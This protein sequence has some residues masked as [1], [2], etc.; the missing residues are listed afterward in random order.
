MDHVRREFIQDF[1]NGLPDPEW[2]TNSEISIQQGWIRLN[3]E[4]A[5]T[6]VRIFM[7]HSRTGWADDQHVMAH[8]RQ[9][10]R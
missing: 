1:F 4:Q 8:F 10:F 2:Q 9:L 3:P 7:R 6:L 5:D